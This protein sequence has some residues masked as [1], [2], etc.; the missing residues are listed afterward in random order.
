VTPGRTPREDIGAAPASGLRRQLRA[1]RRRQRVVAFV[2]VAPL[3]LFLVVNF[4]VPVGYLLF[5]SI[6]DRAAAA[7]LRRTVAEIR[8]WDGVGLPP[9]S[10]FTA[11]AADLRDAQA[12]RT[13]SAAAIRLSS[14]R[15]G[16]QALLG[17][18]AR[19]VSA[20]PGPLTRPALVEIDSRWGEREYWLA[21]KRASARLTPTYLLAVF[22]LQLDDGSRIVPVPE[23]RRLFNQIWLRTLW[24][25]SVVTLVCVLLG[26]PLAYFLA[27][28]KP[29]VAAMLMIFVLLPFWT[30]LLVRTIAWLALLQTHGVVNDLALYL[31]LASE[32]TQLIHNRLGVYVTM[33]HVLLPYMVLPIYSVMRRIPPTYL[34]AAISLGAS[35]VQAF[36]RV[37]LPMTL[38]GLGAGAALVFILAVGFYITPALVGGPNDQ[39]IS[40]FIAY[41]TN[42][43]LNWNAAAALSIV[44]LGLTVSFFLAFSRLVGLDRLTVR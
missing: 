44:L 1:A 12:A 23:S 6:D 19:A 38:H 4:V 27:H 29:R 28:A 33:S 41:Y 7:V 21:M 36:A 30:S 8:G 24:I 14:D 9:D 32:R 15:P 13:L 2:L 11:L 20:S 34:R 31:H 43:S 25:A 35:P 17:K 3:L 16:F 39:M 37:Y 5:R 10:A 18:T 42:E 26:Y 40:Y 22:D